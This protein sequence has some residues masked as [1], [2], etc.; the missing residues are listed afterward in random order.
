MVAKLEQKL[1]TAEDFWEMPEFPGKRFELVHGELVEMPG[2]GGV[3]GVIVMVICEYLRA[4]MRAL[5]GGY[6]A[7]D[8]VGY[9]VARDLDVVRVPDASFVAQERIPPEGIPVAHWPFA[10]DI[11]VEVCSPGDRAE[12]L[13]V[14]VGEYLAGGSRLVVV[15]WPRTRSVTRYEADGTARELG[16]DDVLDG[17]DVLPT[18]RVRV[19]DL[20]AEVV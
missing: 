6:V 18:F 20:F 7:L 8:G 16:P 19:A 11:A 15:V 4:A 12:D 14:K 17:G 1:L 9:I 5:G 13:H 10:P 2:A 3:H